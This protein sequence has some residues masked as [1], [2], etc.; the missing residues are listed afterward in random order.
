MDGLK[1]VDEIIQGHLKWFSKHYARKES[2]SL[3]PVEELISEIRGSS[4]KFEIKRYYVDMI[5]LTFPI[6]K[7]C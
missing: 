3:S 6:P 1:V 4:K 5:F 7:L 2:D